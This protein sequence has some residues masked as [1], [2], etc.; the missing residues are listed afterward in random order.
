M[1]ALKRMIELRQ[2]RAKINQELTDLEPVAIEEALEQSKKTFSVDGI[3]VQIRLKKQ[4]PKRGEYLEL[5][6]RW[7]A[8]EKIAK[9]LIESNAEKLRYH[10]EVIEA[11]QKDILALTTSPELKQAEKEKEA[12]LLELTTE[13]P[14]IAI[15]I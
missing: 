11:N 5:D 9:G 8:V 3:K 7:D 2:E 10:K 4:P 14:T 15:S 12:L 1:Q 6:E 13:Y